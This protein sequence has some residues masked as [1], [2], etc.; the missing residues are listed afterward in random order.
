MRAFPSLREKS[1]GVNS[2]T[3]GED[4]HEVS[5]FVLSGM[6]LMSTVSISGAFIQP[7]KLTCNSLIAPGSTVTSATA[8]VFAMGKIVESTILM[9]PPPNRVAFIFDMAKDRALGT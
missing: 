9:V 4:L 2:E 7:I 6:P 8:R 1:Q 5:P 3:S